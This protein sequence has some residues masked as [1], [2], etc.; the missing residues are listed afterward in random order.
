MV[1]FL[2]TQADARRMAVLLA[3]YD[4]RLQAL[5]RSTQA[6]HTSIEGG[7]IEVYDKSGRR[8]GSV[9]I[10]PDGTVAVVPVNSPPPPTP[11]RPLVEPVLAGLVIAWDGQWDDK[12]L[13][14]ADFALVQVHIGPAAGFVPSAATLA[15]AITDVHGGSLTV[16]VPGYTAVWVRFLGVNTAAAT[17]PASIAVQGA[18]RQAVSQD[19]IDG[20]VTDTKIAASAVSAAKIALGAVGTAALAAGAVLE[21][22]LG[23]AAVTLDK[24]GKG[25]VTLNALG[26]ALADG[27]T[28]RWIDAMADPAAWRILNQAP[29][30]K[31]EHLSG[32][33]DAPTGQSVARAT[34]YT[35]V[36]GVVQV[37]YDP[38]VLYRI[39]ARVRTVTTSVTGPDA[40]Y[41]GALG[42][43]ANGIDL[44]SRQGANSYA[45]AHYVAAA[46]TPQ[47]VES[48]WTTYVGYVRGR[49]APGQLG[50]GGRAPDARD[51]GVVHDGVRF[52]SPILYLNYGS[53][54][55][56]ASGVMEVDAFTIE[57]LKTGIVDSTNLVVGSVTTAALATDSVTAGK[58]AADSIGAREITAGSLTAIEL[59]AGSI[60]ADKL[61]IA[62]GANILSDPSFEGA[63]TAAVVQ[64]FSTY[65]TQDK[66]FGNG[67]PA[68]LKIDSTSAT[69]AF[70]AV[71]LSL[72]PISPGDQ[73]YIAADYFAPEA[74][75]GTEISVHVRWEAADST[76]LGYAKAA[77]PTPVRDAWTRLSATVT[78]PAGAWRGR[79][80]V[81]AAGTAGAVWWDNA[82]CRP[83]LAAVQIGDG[84]ITAPKILVGSVTTDK[85]VA[86]SITAEKI[87]A[88]AITTDKL[89][90][91]AVTADKLAVN[92][93]TASKILAGSIDATHI[94]AGAITAD[95]LAIGTT[96]N[97]IADP[98]FEGSITAARV[99]A[100]GA[101]WS[102]IAGGNES[103]TALQVDATSA[104]PLTRTLNLGT[105]AV[106][107][108]E[109]LYL[110]V[111]YWVSTDWA[112]ASVRL[113]ADWQDSAGVHVAWGVII[114]DS[115]V[116]N[117]WTRIS[118]QY[119]APSGAVRARLA[120]GTNSSTAGTVRFD[121]CEVRPVIG[122]RGTGSR[123]ELSPEG[124]RLY[125]DDGDETVSLVSGSRNFLTLTTNSVP[126]ATIDDKGNGHFA[127]LAVAGGLTIGG[128]SFED[129]LTYAPRGLVA[130]GRQTE[131]VTGGPGEY[132]YMEL[133]FLADP[134]RMY[135]LVLDCFSLASTE[136]GEV[137]VTFR[138]GGASTPS[139]NSTNLQTR[140][141]ESAGAAYRPIRLEL[142]RS[143]ADFGAGLHRILT[144]FSSMWGPPGMTVTLFGR[145][146]VPG[147][148]YI[149]DIGP[150]IPDTGVYNTGGG[151]VT[152]PRQTITRTYAA[153]WSGS[154]AHRS[155]YNSYYGN[156][157]LQGYF[158]GTNGLQAS[159]VGFPSGLGADLAGAEI[160]AVAIYLYF[161][162]WYSASG[163]TAVIR[164]HGHGSRPGTFSCDSDSVTASFG[165]NEGKWVDISRIFDNTGWRGI[166]LDPNNTSSQY[167]GRARGAGEGYAPQ[168]RVT[169]TK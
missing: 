16:A 69:P 62:G 68:S 138:D 127:N 1:N 55:T 65:A 63:Y 156:K 145:T 56:G 147:H 118:G 59:A 48:G 89:S 130:Y 52:I 99:A 141:F 124:L 122:S 3:E 28:T 168:L 12:N 154:Y 76:V 128:D 5:E 120:L 74:W 116:R 14:P 27:V 44:V 7:A 18:P 136:G 11:S 66:T 67:S 81:E 13:T 137:H 21:D 148:M 45:S 91:L 51:P 72:L 143:G 129:V 106:L 126:V 36:R 96:G 29:G 23:K 35:V 121:N 117:A 70:R 110:S 125:G 38:D 79:V 64:R 144:T 157:M 31:W 115:P 133:S 84:A 6:S 80:R 159:L 119:Q 86:L 71:E 114:V 101:S 92:S 85:L 113:Y 103:P 41:V 167:Y 123:A 135:R 146:D 17:G 9:G 46:N 54:T 47:P 2:D 60:T 111:D 105:A 82:V 39:S 142:I 83:V 151:T 112:G 98:S 8:R 77:T 42:I 160:N 37:P 132:G 73:L 20:I 108:G 162:H 150:S 33:T 26:G 149:E 94:K 88:L 24:I 75:A 22:K 32:I 87:A 100:A 34:G 166:A 97:L 4:R 158:D 53:T 93:V 107:P 58:I 134:T 104:T 165:R 161:E 95:Q 30:G 15:G 109:S 78:A 43:A 164:A 90:A 57:A 131:A 50:T 139:I 19:L 25:A 49:A 163:G 10:Q 153:A 102:V 169:Y 61:T 155:G 40:L 152:P 140:V